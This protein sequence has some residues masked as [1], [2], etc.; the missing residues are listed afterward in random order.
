MGAC[1]RLKN[2]SQNVHVLILGASAFATLYFKRDFADINKAGDLIPDCLKDLNLI[3]R[4]FKTRALSLAGG[5][6][7]STRRRH[8]EEREN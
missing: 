7:C 4:V 3:T 6:R 8:W 2:A 1:G 5:P